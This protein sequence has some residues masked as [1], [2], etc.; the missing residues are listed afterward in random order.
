MIT[1]EYSKLNN[2][3][4]QQAWELLFES[5]RQPLNIRIIDRDNN[6]CFSQFDLFDSEEKDRRINM[7]YDE[8]VEWLINFYD[9]NEPENN[10][11]EF[12]Y[13]KIIFEYC[14]RDRDEID[15][16]NNT[17]AI[18]FMNE[19][20]NQHQSNWKD[21]IKVIQNNQNYKFSAK[22]ENETI[23]SAH[24]GFLYVLLA[25][26]NKI[27]FSNCILT[28]N[29]GNNFTL[30]KPMLLSDT[31]DLILDKWEYR[32]FYLDRESE[33]N[34]VNFVSVKPVESDLSKNLFKFLTQ[35]KQ[36]DSLKSIRIVDNTCKKWLLSFCLKQLKYL[37]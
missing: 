3:F 20:K 33:N 1:L 31:N 29:T 8:I 12:L 5:I 4:I 6:C 30:L 17:C 18:S 14:T 22:I 37:K 34:N 16:N 13:H 32:E 7:E 2:Y 11:I 35:T 24:L 15:I 27:T 19:I 9:N 23:S 21:K 10:T 25:N 28:L 26:T 36:I